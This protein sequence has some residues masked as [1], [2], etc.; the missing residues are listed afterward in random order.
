[1]RDEVNLV[2]SG[3]IRNGADIAKALALGADA[4]AISTGVLVAMGCRMC[5]LCSTGRCPRGIATQ[6]PALRRR[7]RV[8]DAAQRV[9][10]YLNATIEELEMFTQ[11]SGKTCTGNLERDDL[12][13][14]NA[15]AAA[16][17][18]VKLVGTD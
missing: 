7:I 9:E 12:R 8:D 11:L 14:L 18:G 10:N 3:A 16:I 5:G 4:V 6:D 13:A 1:M 15:D 17:A 2:I